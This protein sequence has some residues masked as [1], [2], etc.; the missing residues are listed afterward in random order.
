MWRTAPTTRDPGLALSIHQGEEARSPAAADFPAAISDGAVSAAPARTPR[1]PDLG[2][3][4][5]Q[6]ARRVGRNS[7]VPVI[8]SARM[9]DAP[10]WGR[11]VAQHPAPGTALGPGDAVTITVG[12]PPSVRVPDVRGGDETDMLAVLR[13]AGL[14]P[15]RRIVRRSN[16]IP[17][18][19]IVRTRPRTGS[20]VPH[21]T[22]V[23][24]VVATPRP[25][26]GKRARRHEERVRVRRLPDGSFLSQPFDD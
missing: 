24:Y 3:L 8:V 19:H 22:K 9:T 4:E 12:Q 2:G 20:E 7:S 23:T 10:H 16:R 14:R 21:G 11:V 1:A 18:G 26:H 17:D 5:A 13:D 25:M 6:E 15:D